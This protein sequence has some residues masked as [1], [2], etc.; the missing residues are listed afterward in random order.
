MSATAPVNLAS[1]APVRSPGVIELYWDEVWNKGN[2]ELIREICNDP[3]IRHDIGSVTHLSHD[4]QIRRVS[5]Q[6]A[7]VKPYFTHEVLNA[8]DHHV[9][10]V[11]NMV[12]AADPTLEI[13]DRDLPR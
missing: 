1:D 4:E 11:W 12:G 2:V 8:D 5:Q 13:C 7:M 3:I 10:S 6:I 9:T